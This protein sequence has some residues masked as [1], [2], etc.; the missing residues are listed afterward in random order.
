MKY[1]VEIISGIVANV[2]T[3]T[4][5]TP[6]YDEGQLVYEITKAQ[7]DSVIVGKTTE[8]ELLAMV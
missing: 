2:G 8:A 1:Y 5:P 6:V 7:H 3:F 4:T